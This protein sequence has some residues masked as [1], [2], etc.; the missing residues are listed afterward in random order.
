M[1]SKEGASDYRYF[2]EPDLP[3][4]HITEA[5]LTAVKTQMPA[6]P[7]AL[8]EKFTKAIGLSEYDAQVLTENK[9]IAAYFEGILKHT[10]NAKAAANWLMVNIKGYLNEQALEINDF[11]L[12][13]AK[14]AE[15]ISLIDE[16]KISN[17]A[18]SQRLFPAMLEEH[19]LS[20]FQLAEKLNLLQESNSD[21]LNKWIADALAKYPEKVIEY[22]AGKKS[23]TGLF[24]GEVMKASKGKAD[25]K[26]A[27]KLL[28][29]AL[30]KA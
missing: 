4:L 3:P 27:T 5:F 30:E 25:P 6:L 9:D 13:P 1:R 16:N 21:E 23:L 14:I 10:H 2:P 12:Q 28:I 7:S 15:I 18:A 17:S 22:K 19:H 24:M 20:A 29:D 8:Y 11:V 26:A